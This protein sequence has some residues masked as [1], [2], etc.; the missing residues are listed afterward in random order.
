MLIAVPSKGRAGLTTTNKI[1]P[2]LSTFYIP[3]SEYHQYKGLV[4]NI[5]CVPKEV[6]GI[7][8]T[9]NWILENTD[10]K[11]VVFLDDDAKN[12]G[13]NKL[14]ERKTKKIEV[15][16]EG[17]WA[18]E[19]LKFFDLTEQLGYKIWGT[20]TESSPRGTYPYKPF[21]TRSYVTASC[22]GIVNDGEYL[23]DP[24]F[25]VKE[26]YEICLRH[27]KDKGGILAVRYLH[28]ENE[29]WV[30]DGGCKDYRTIDMERDAIKRLIKLY[31]SMISSAK[32]KANEFTI[33]LNL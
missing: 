2:N 4:K 28:W 32:R 29:H 22:M 23:F 14:E 21:L 13:Y 25:K 12:V 11:W 33:K 19:F 24:D 27:I 7:T 31:P 6:R 17:F 16:D 1:L 26:D 18:E 15:R 10:E 9:R 30:T 5:V 8:D 3:E 20:R